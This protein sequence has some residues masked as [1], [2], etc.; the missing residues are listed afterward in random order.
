MTGFTVA[1]EEYHKEVAARRDTQAEVT[2]LRVQL[3]GQAARLTALS[4]EERARTTMERLAADLNQ[5]IIALEQEVAK[6]RVD[7]DTSLAEIDELSALK[8][9]GQCLS[10]SLLRSY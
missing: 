10:L 1:Q 4:A 8:R 3:S 5:S 9:F 6:I 7:R 2:R